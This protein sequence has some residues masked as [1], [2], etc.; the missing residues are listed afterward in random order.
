MLAGIYIL[1]EIKKKSKKNGFLNC[2][3]IQLSGADPE[4]L[5]WGGG[6]RGALCWPPWLSDEKDFRFQIV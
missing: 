6:G 1:F 5:K 3:K 2:Y 4:I